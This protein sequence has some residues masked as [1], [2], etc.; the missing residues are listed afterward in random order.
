[1]PYL[2]AFL[3]G[4]SP[5]VYWVLA[6]TLPEDLLSLC[7]AAFVAQFC[8]GYG[9]NAAMPFVRYISGERY[10]STINYL[11]IPLISLVM[12]LPM[13]ASGWLVTRL[14]FQTFFLLDSLLVLPAWMAAYIGFRLIVCPAASPRAIASSE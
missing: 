5:L 9:L 13:A 12:L 2:A 8:F 3:L 6:Q 7:M 11:Y 14:G 4:L 10:R 1:M